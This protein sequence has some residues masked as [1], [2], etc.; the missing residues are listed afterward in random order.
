MKPVYQAGIEHAASAAAER[1]LGPPTP[2]T[3]TLNGKH[4]H[5]WCN[6][7]PRVGYHGIPTRQVPPPRCTYDSRDFNQINNLSV[8]NPYNYTRDASKCTRGAKDCTPGASKCTQDA[9]NHLPVNDEYTR[10]ASNY[11]RNASK[12][13]QYVY[14][15]VYE[16]LCIFLFNA[17]DFTYEAWDTWK[18]MHLY[19]KN[20]AFTA[21]NYISMYK[22]ACNIVW[23]AS[24]FAYGVWKSSIQKYVNKIIIIWN[25]YKS[26]WTACKLF[27]DSNN[28]SNVFELGNYNKIRCNRLIPPKLLKTNPYYYT[29]LYCL[30]FTNN[31]LSSYKLRVITKIIK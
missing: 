18:I 5:L 10:C 7:T 8:L 15:I 29:M 21:W 30:K 28:I 11:T 9:C 2:T 24:N 13:L 22:S 17:C 26:T 16:F 3:P 14:N 27:H 20:T 19:V 31:S 12:L 1:A 23:D 6:R 4:K 25:V